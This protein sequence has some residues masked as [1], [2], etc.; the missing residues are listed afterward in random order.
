MTY[1][2]SQPPSL[3]LKDLV[4]DAAEVPAEQ[5]APGTSKCESMPAV[6]GAELRAGECCEL[7]S[8]SVFGV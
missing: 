4:K 8:V 7:C 1:P 5:D 6:T 3:Q 2:V